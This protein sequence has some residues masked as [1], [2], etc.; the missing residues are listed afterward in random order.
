MIQ[1]TTFGDEP[2][3][4]CTVTSTKNPVVVGHH[5][6][7]QIIEQTIRKLPPTN[8]VGDIQQGGLWPVA[9]SKVIDTDL[10]VHNCEKKLQ[11][12]RGPQ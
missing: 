3:F 1:D 4:I 2:E 11:L 10:A 7:V 12:Q 8:S 5:I 9:S 6:T